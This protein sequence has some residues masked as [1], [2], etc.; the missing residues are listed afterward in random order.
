M[1]ISS[2]VVRA[3]NQ[4]RISRFHTLRGELIPGNEL[5]TVPIELLLRVIGVQRKGPWLSKSAVKELSRLLGHGKDKKVLEIGGGK[6]TRF[7]SKR[8]S[9]LLTIEEDSQWASQIIKENSKDLSKFQLINANLTEWLQTR[10]EQNMNFDIVLIDG[11]TD[12][13]RKKTL[14]TLS[15][16]NPKPI[17]VLDNSDRLIF[18]RLKFT[19][20]PKRVIR[21]LGLIRHPFQATETTF[22][23]F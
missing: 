5:L 13:A 16:L 4:Q 15:A 21:H 12:E 8:T 9:F 17:Y 10:T 14:E 20:E 2:R 1:K 7:F 11:G 23:F 3:G 6:S 22:Y 18:S 19:Y